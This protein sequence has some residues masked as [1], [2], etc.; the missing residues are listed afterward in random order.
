MLGSLGNGTEGNCGVETTAEVGFGQFPNITGWSC[1]DNTNP[2][3]VATCGVSAPNSGACDLNGEHY[4]G[5]RNALE[6]LLISVSTDANSRIIWGTIYVQNE[7][8]IFNVGP[9]SPDRNSWWG[10]VI[11]FTGD[12]VSHEPLGGSASGLIIDKVSCKNKTTGQKVTIQ[13]DGTTTIWDCEQAGLAVDP[14]DEVSMKSMGSA[15]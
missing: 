8:R 13:V 3:Q 5:A 14:G 15:E 9:P 11:S 12:G 10:Y 1:Q 6:N 7:L 2:S 4:C